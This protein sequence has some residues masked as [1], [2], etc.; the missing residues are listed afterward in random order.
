MVHVEKVDIGVFLPNVQ[1]GMV[2]NRFVNDFV[3]CKCP[4][5]MMCSKGAQQAI[6]V[7]FIYICWRSMVTE[8]VNYGQNCKVSVKLPCP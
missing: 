5:L 2:H 8:E 4:P 6:Y 7:L 3:V 1:S